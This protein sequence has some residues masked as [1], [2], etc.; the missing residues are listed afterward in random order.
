ME[1]KRKESMIAVT[2][3]SGGAQA[4]R[5]ESY[6][7]RLMWSQ[8]SL[9]T[10]KQRHKAKIKEFRNLQLQ[11]RVFSGHQRPAEILLW[12]INR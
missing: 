12:N 4:K 11:T 6:S 7:S 5:A 8:P 9:F 3:G 2:E 1:E 10:T